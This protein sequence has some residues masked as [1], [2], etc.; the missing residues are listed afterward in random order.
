MQ[1]SRIIGLIRGNK[2]LN[3]N[4]TDPD[5]AL[6]ETHIKIVLMTVFCVFKNLHRDMEDTKKKKRPGV[7]FY[8]WEL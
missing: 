2:S 7:G 1:R 5:V 8:R 3:E 6:E 4:Q